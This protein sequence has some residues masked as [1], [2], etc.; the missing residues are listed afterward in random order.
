[1][2]NLSISLQSK[3]FCFKMSVFYNSISRFEASY[4]A[5]L[6]QKWENRLFLLAVSVKPY[7]FLGT[8]SVTFNHLLF[9]V[10]SA[11]FPYK[12]SFSA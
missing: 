1:M 5:V 12:K 8:F 11:G 4:L 9:N 10:I 3:A 2:K 6:C 7:I